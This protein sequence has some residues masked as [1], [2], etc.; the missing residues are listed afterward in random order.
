MIVGNVIGNNPVTPKAYILKTNTGEEIPAVLVAEQ[1][2]FTATENDIREGKT[3]G[4][5]KGV[6]TGEK[7]IPAYHTSGGTSIITSGKPL[8]IYLPDL[9]AY[10]Y[11][12]LQVIVC[13]FNSSL[14]N[15]VAT[16]KVAINN[17][18]YEVLS[19]D[20]IADITKNDDGKTI[21]LGITNETDKP[22]ILRYITYKEI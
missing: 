16:S 18:V 20:S 22:L 6:I 15:S 7:V 5:E 9:N 19:V 11:T 13:A 12:K 3:A 14:S 17:K 2:L 4:T 10:D 21:D 8:T 1:T